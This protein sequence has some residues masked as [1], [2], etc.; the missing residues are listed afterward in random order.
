LVAPQ[1]MKSVKFEVLEV[2]IALTFDFQARRG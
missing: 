1:V 2:K